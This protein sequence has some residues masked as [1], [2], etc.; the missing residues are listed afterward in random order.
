LESGVAASEAE[1][2]QFMSY[3]KGVA[4]FDLTSGVFHF[5]AS[6]LK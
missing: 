5:V 3:A 1:S 4:Q 2:V 6:C